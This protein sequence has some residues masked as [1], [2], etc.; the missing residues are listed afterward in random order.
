ML[1]VMVFE[2]REV[3]FET[4]GGRRD[5]G[6][7]EVMK[8]MWQGFEQH[9]SGTYEVADYPAT[10]GDLRQLESVA[11]LPCLD[12]S[13]KTISLGRSADRCCF[14]K[15]LPQMSCVWTRRVPTTPHQALALYVYQTALDDDRRPN[16]LEHSDSLWVAV[17]SAADWVQAVELKRLE[18]KIEFRPRIFVN[19]VLAVDYSARSSIHEGDEAAV[20][21]QE[22]AVEDQVAG[23]ERLGKCWRPVEPVMYD[24]L[25]LRRAETTEIPDLAHAEPFCQPSLEP[26]PLIVK[27]LVDPSPV[28]RPAAVETPPPLATIDVMAVAFD[29]VAPTSRTMFFSGSY[30]DHGTTSI[31]GSTSH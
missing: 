24:T 22:G 28:K 21:I 19:A 27:A 12:R 25:Q 26:Y 10:F 18:E 11:V 9:T 23:K 7:F 29:S 17:D 5:S 4:V 20:L 31:M 1:A 6:V 14:E 16:S 15:N 2:P 3:S 13:D 8:H 30:L